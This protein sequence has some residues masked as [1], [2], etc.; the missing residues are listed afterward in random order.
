[1]HSESCD[2]ETH[3]LIGPSKNCQAR[4]EELSK[5]LET[6]WSRVFDMPR[7]YDSLLLSFE[8]L[9]GLLLAGNSIGQDPIVL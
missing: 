5:H 6:H 4:Y 9:E 7:I 1:M 8:V 2:S 3:L